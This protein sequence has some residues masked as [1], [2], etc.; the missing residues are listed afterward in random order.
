MDE[1]YL[2]LGSNIGDSKAIMEM[3]LN[4]IGAKLGTI[5]QK[6]AYYETAPWGD[7]EQ[8]AYLN[9]VVA[10]K[11]DWKNNIDVKGFATWF[12]QE[13][14]EI[15][16]SLGR[17]RDAN[18]QFGPRTIDIDLLSFG[19]VVM[20]TELLHLPHPRMHLRKFVLVPLC[21]IAPLWMHP[22]LGKSVEELLTICPDMGFVIKKDCN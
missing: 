20:E 17:K 16:R 7:L 4:A 18:N 12:M 9:L 2:I 14:L 11:P 19:K 8:P 22:I 21:E 10:V 6:S 3:A 13:L 15:E 1:V 5:T